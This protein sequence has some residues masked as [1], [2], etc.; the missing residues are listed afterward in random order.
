MNL[1]KR[2]NNYKNDTGEKITTY[3]KDLHIRKRK[4]VLF[5]IWPI[6]GPQCIE[7]LSTALFV[8]CL[9]ISQIKQY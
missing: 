5:F 4:L 2:L 9:T 3:V 1:E 7:D 6:L 8:G